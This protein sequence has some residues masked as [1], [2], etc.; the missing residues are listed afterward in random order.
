MA[1]VQPPAPPAR[2]PATPLRV[3]MVAS[4][5]APFSKTGGLADVASALP[6]ALGRLGHEVTLFTPRYAGVSAGA[7][8]ARGVGRHRRH[9]VHRRPVRRAARRRRP[10]DAGRMPAALPPA[11]PLQ[12]RRRR[13]RRQRAALRASWSSPRSSGRRSRPSRS[14]S[15]TPTTGRRA[16]CRPT[17]GSTSPGIPRWPGPDGV[18]HPQPRVSGNLRQGVA[19]AARPRLGPDFTVERPRVLGSRSACS[20]P[21][22]TSPTRSP[23]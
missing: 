15:C 6:R 2:R 7:V 21:A 11:R 10:G 14:T 16:W 5:A 19:A 9:A 17:C 12:R 18:H 1:R 13:L 22:S 3:L 20:R 8:A 4:E 23:R